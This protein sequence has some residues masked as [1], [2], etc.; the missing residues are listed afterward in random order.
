MNWICQLESAKDH[1]DPSSVDIV[2]ACS[3]LKLLQF[4]AL[5]TRYQVNAAGRKSLTPQLEYFL[6]V[7]E[8]SGMPGYA[9][10][11]M[12]QRI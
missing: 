4:Y 3:K 2:L 7:R 5:Q 8:R 6:N 12:K 1:L 9:S 10:T 11:K